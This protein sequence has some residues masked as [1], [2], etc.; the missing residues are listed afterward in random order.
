MLHI[1][2]QS[3]SG[4]N[5][6]ALHKSLQNTSALTD[7]NLQLSATSL[8]QFPVWRGQTC[9]ASVIQE[10]LGTL[11]DYFV[12]HQIPWKCCLCIQSLHYSIEIHQWA[13]CSLITLNRQIILSHSYIILC[14][15]YKPTHPI[16]FR[17]I[18]LN[19]YTVCPCLLNSTL[20]IES[21]HLK[22]L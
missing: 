8:H 21:I 16:C 5:T 13:T 15:K 17:R 20:S 19:E 14:R 3:H 10:I 2:Q 4:F 6:C 1:N 22:V 7:E 9:V 11:K 12:C 18:V